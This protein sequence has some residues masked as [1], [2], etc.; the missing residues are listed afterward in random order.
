MKGRKTIHLLAPDSLAR[1][2]WEGG[3]GLRNLS[4][5]SEYLLAKQMWRV[6]SDPKS[7]LSQLI[8]AK[9]GRVELKGITNM[10]FNGN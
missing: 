1:P 3:L 5:F 7:F 6:F 8:I 4:I 9:Y 2:L 10:H